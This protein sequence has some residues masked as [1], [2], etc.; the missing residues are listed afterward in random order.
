M[1][2]INNKIVNDFQENTFTITQLN[3]MLK[4]AINRC[5]KQYTQLKWN[6]FEKKFVTRNFFTADYLKNFRDLIDY[7]RHKSLSDAVTVTNFFVEAD[8]DQYITKR[9]TWGGNYSVEEYDEFV[10]QKLRSGVTIR[11][12]NKNFTYLTNFVDIN[13]YF[14]YSYFENGEGGYDHSFIEYSSDEDTFNDEYYNP[15]F[16]RAYVSLNG[17]TFPFFKEP[18]W[19]CLSKSRDK[20]RADVEFKIIT[21]LNKD[22]GMFAHIADNSRV[23][24]NKRKTISNKDP[25]YYAEHNNNNRN[26][27][28]THSTKQEIYVFT[29]AEARQLNPRWEDDYYAYDDG[30]Y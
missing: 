13:Y 21:Y 2:T 25:E 11:F 23:Y 24:Y 8:N 15:F 20:I 19:Q 12:P 17:Q 28:N 22:L 10:K 7:L 16:H 6:K 26:F 3:K 1:D 5:Q 14:V 29:L 4:D 18:I 27:V 30:D 9:L